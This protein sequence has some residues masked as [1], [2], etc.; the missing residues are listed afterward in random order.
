MDDDAAAKLICVKDRAYGTGLA[1]SVRDATEADPKL[2]GMHYHA[3]AGPVTTQAEASATGSLI[4]TV[5]GI[6]DDL[7]E[8]GRIFL[9]PAR[10]PGP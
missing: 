2:A 1:D 6:P 5:E 4:Y 3:S 7:S 8:A 10:S 9:E